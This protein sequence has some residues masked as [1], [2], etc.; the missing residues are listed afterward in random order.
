M[1][2]LDFQLLQDQKAVDVIIA[3]MRKESV[4]HALLFTGTEGIGKR[5]AAL[6]FAMACNCTLHADRMNPPGNWIGAMAGCGCRSCR[7]ILSGSHPDV[8]RIVPSGILIKIDRVRELR[9]SLSMKPYE[10]RVRVVI[11]EGAQAMNP[12]ASNALLKILEEPPDRTV[13]VL[14]AADPGDLLPT[15][16]SRCRQLRFHPVPRMTLAALWQQKYGLSTRDADILALLADSSPGRIDMNRPTDRDA[17]I[18]RR[19]WLLGRLSEIMTRTGRD[20]SVSGLLAVAEG[21]AR[22]KA[23]VDAALNVIQSWLRD[24]VVAKYCP[25]KIL[26]Q[27]AVGDIQR[28]SLKYTEKSLLSR[29]DAVNA[30]QRDLRSNANVR[31]T[32]EVM[33]L[34]LAK[35]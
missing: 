6:L 21:L 13:F 3:L 14:T 5:A 19:R 2:A 7:K 28:I 15:I 35:K 29:I 18:R 20:V 1:S 27:D 34:Q 31:L 23:E 22:K 25:E 32:L 9:H 26:N 24:L 17:W 10:A 33:V 8:H 12:E 16:V 30:A 11:I 4:P